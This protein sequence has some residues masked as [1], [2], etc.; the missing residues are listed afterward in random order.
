MCKISPCDISALKLL[1]KLPD[2]ANLN[3]TFTHNINFTSW[4]G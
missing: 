2:Q 3:Y 1:L 4:A